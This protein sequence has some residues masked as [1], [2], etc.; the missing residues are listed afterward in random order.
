[1]RRFSM[2]LQCGERR[3]CRVGGHGWGEKVLVPL[4]CCGLSCFLENFSVF[5]SC[6][7]RVQNRRAPCALDLICRCHRKELVIIIRL[8][9]LMSRQRKRRMKERFPRCCR[10]C[11][12][13]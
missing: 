10:K 6:K 3:E 12:T 1:M 13:I 4:L 7:S 8:L 9:I 11:T 2:R 5:A